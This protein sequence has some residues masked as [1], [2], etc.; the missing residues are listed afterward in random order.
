MGA[1]ILTLAV[2]AIEGVFFLADKTRTFGSIRVRAVIVVA[3]IGP[4][5]FALQV[6]LRHSSCERGK[7]CM[8]AE[9]FFFFNNLHRANSLQHS[10]MPDSSTSLWGLRQ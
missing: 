6:F 5:A 1:N 3:K 10:G 2:A 9:T 8:Y 4:D 7:N